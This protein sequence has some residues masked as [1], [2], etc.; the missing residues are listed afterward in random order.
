MR[1]SSGEVG[2]QPERGEAMLG[3]VRTERG[4]LAFTPW[5]LLEEGEEEKCM[6]GEKILP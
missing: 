3:K 6:T 5:R 1:R 2:G 4:P